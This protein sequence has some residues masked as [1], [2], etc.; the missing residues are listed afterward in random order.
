MTTT[1]KFLNLTP[2]PVTVYTFDAERVQSEEG[3]KTSDKV[4]EVVVSPSGIQARV[5]E[6]LDLVGTTTVEGASGVVVLYDPSYGEL[7]AV[8]KEG[9]RVPMPERQEGVL[10]IV[11]DLVRRA[12]PERLDFVSP[13]KFVRDGH[14]RIIAAEG[15]KAQ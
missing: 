10:V 12:A 14:G 13:A 4:S 9:D 6:N 1:T 5:E 11:S 15:L 7:F 2:H 3:H 8:T